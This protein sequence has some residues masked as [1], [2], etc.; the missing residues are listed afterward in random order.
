[1]VQTIEAKWA[2]CGTLPNKGFGTSKRKLY[3]DFVTFYELFD[4]RLTQQHELLVL[5][6]FGE[7]LLGEE[8]S[9]LHQVQ[10]VVGFGEVPNSQ[11]VGG[12]ELALQKVTA[13]PFDS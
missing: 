11:T 8:L 5:N 2:I 6:H 10:A 9:R 4:F 1:M 3:L 13:G 12:I 7:M